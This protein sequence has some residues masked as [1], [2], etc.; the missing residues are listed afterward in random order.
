M[1]FN[2]IV[3]DF[4]LD[5]D[6]LRTCNCKPKCQEVEYSAKLSMNKYPSKQYSKDININDSKFHS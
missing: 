2:L 6:N 4:P 1:Y 3:G 5:P